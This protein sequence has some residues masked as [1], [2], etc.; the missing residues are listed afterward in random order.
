M[1]TLRKSKILSLINARL[2]EGMSCSKLSVC[3]ALGVVLGIFPVIGTTTLLCTLAAF[4]FRLNLPII[5]LVNYAVYPLQLV[6]L[7][8]FYEAGSRLFTGKSSLYAGSEMIELLRTDLWGSLTA[9]WDLTLYAASTW[10]FISPLLLFVLYGVLK[11]VVR[12]FCSSQHSPL[13]S[14]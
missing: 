4:A 14:R 2:K 8:F 1:I 13:T 11:P 12:K 9:F 7:A 10:L 5:Q 3:L 6:L